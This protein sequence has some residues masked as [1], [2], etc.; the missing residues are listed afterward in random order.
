MLASSAFAAQ[1]DRWRNGGPRIRPQDGR[2][3][4]LIAAGVARSATFRALV[5]RIEASNVFVYVAM[6]P[7]LKSGLSGRVTWMART[8]PYRYLRVGISTDLSSGQIIATLGHELQH[9]VEVIEDP[10]VVDERS[11]VSLY[12]RIGRPSRATVTS[13]WETL[14]AQEAGNRV[15]R[16]LVA[17]PATAALRVTDGDKL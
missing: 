7:L 15:R 16:E 6:S 4:M 13:G 12:K 17:T 10:G 14:A 5:D 9:V 1:P 11:L 2:T 8:G 3:T